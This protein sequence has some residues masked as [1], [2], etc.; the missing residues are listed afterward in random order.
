MKR[1]PGRFSL[2]SGAYVEASCPHRKKTGPGA[3]P[4]CYAR[5]IF[6]FNNLDERRLYLELELQGACGMALDA[7]RE[8]GRVDIELEAILDNVPGAVWVREGGGPVNLLASVAVTVSKL[9][10]RS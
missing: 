4:G 3:C 10:K 8:L 1:K 7:G 2:P 9:E 5:S 6:A